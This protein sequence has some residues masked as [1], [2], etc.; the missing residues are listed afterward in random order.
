MRPIG[1]WYHGLRKPGPYVHFREVELLLRK[2]MQLE[3]WR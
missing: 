1:L 2:A 3:R